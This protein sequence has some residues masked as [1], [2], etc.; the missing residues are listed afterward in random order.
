MGN[1]Q[2]SKEWFQKAVDINPNSDA[3]KK[4]Q[5]LLTSH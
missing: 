3:G 1:I 5:Q 2:E 4:A